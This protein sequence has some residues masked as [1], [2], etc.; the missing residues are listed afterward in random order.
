M[1]TKTL[2]RAA[3][4]TVLKAPIQRKNRSDHCARKHKATILRKRPPRSLVHGT[5]S[6][7]WGAKILLKTGKSRLANPTEL[8]NPALNAQDLL[9]IGAVI[10]QTLSTVIFAGLI[11][12]TLFSLWMPANFIPGGLEGQVADA[13]SA[14]SLVEQTEIAEGIL[15]ANFPVNR[16]GIVVGHRGH[17]SGAVCANGLTELEINSNV[18]T[19]VQQ[20]LIKLGYE[21]D[22]LDEFDARLANYEAGLLLRSIL[23]P[24]IILTT[25]HRFQGRRG[26]SQKMDQALRAWLPV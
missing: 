5:V 14:D 22:L 15:P 24:A 7:A 18:A 16:I 2:A 4:F 23:I 20:K 9:K 13:V 6:L 21:V 25:R 8:K 26:F 10:W 12:A 3:F 11:T 1:T 19:Y 17:D